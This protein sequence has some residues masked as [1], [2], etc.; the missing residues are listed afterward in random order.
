MVYAYDVNIFGGSVH[1]VKKNTDASVVASKEIGLEVNTD[2]TMYR[3][4]YGDQ[5]A[6]RSHNINFD[7][8]SFER[9]EQF[10]YLGTTST[11]QNSIHEEIKSRLMSGNI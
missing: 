1:T 8:T 9:I 10:I 3:F 7:N 2:I 5:T 6:G 4:M 11:N